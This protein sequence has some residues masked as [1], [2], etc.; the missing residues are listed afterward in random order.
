MTLGDIVSVIAAA[1]EVAKEWGIPNLPSLLWQSARQ[2]N[3]TPDQ[4][5]DIASFAGETVS[6]SS[7]GSLDPQYGAAQASSKSKPGKKA[8]W[9]PFDFYN[10]AI[11]ARHEAGTRAE[12]DFSVNDYDYYNDQFL[13]DI[14]TSSHA[15]ICGCSSCR[16][17]RG[18]WNGYVDEEDDGDHDHNW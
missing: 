8:A 13:D 4:L 12:S 15:D 9:R 3:G 16:P 7:L 11:A 10:P 1:K 14:S 17:W 18:N 5:A 2:L 6:T